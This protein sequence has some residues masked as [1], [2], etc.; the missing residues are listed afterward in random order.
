[1]GISLFLGGH[2]TKNA[3]YDILKKER[4]DFRVK[5][6]VLD[7]LKRSFTV[8]RLL[9]L[10]PTFLLINAACTLTQNG[11]EAM[12]A[13]TLVT[14][15][16]F[17][18]LVLFSVARVFAENDLDA[19]R[20]FAATG[21]TTLRER[22]P[23]VLRSRSF[24]TGLGIAL[25]FLLVLPLE[26]SHYALTVLW[27]G[28]SGFSSALARLAVIGVSLPI[29]ALFL[30]WARLSAW[31]HYIDGMGVYLADRGE[32]GAPIAT[33]FQGSM[34]AR[35]LGFG[36][37]GD[38]APVNEPT[39]TI[40]AAGRAY[41]RREGRD[42]PRLLPLRVLALLFIYGLGGILLR[43]AL[44]VLI[45]IVNI[46]GALHEIRWWIPLFIL[47]LLFGSFWG[48][49]LLRALHIRRR[50]FKNLKVLCRENGY[51]VCGKRRLYLSLF[52]YHDGINFTIHANKKAYDCKLFGALRRHFE[53]FFDEKGVCRSRHAFR[54]RRVEFFSYTTIYHFDFDSE[55]H[56]I[57]LVLPV[58]KEICAG[59]EHWN[60]PIDTGVR[61]GDYRIFNATG[62][63]N[64]LTRDCV[65]RD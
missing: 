34:M 62:F 59:N 10:Y 39:G 20:A 27:F 22:A 29:T 56:K 51:E 65:E 4:G 15:A 32:V 43:F 25:A 60:R 5:E 8:A 46:A 54:F 1:M 50:F 3:I 49:F 16:V 64:A 33:H 30:F 21:A 7:Y 52:R 19:N 31:Q 13:P 9:L 41:L 36:E 23:V 48:F 47:A 58:P 24:L 12:D 45:G 57:C 55:N 17:S 63:L 6:M 28:K 53:L 61:V 14:A 40:S 2:Y 38:G 11:Y 35:E 42:K 37:D 44:P 26:A 18:F